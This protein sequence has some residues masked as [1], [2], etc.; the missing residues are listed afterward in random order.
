MECGSRA[1][2]FEISK[3]AKALPFGEGALGGRKFR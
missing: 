2:A 1:P 3:F